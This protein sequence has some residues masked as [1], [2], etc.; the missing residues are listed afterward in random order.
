MDLQ[1][2]SIP[3]IQAERMFD[4][5]P[6]HSGVRED[7]QV[8]LLILGGGSVGQAVLLQAMNQAVLTSTNSVRIDVVDRAPEEAADALA[9]HFSQDYVEREGNSFRI[10]SRNA[11]GELQIRFHGYALRSMALAEFLRT[12]QQGPEPYTYVAVCLPNPDD[13]LYCSYLFEQVFGENIG[14]TALAFRMSQSPIMQAHLQNLP[15]CGRV[16]FLGTGEEYIGLSQVVDIPEEQRIRKYNHMY[17]LITSGMYRSPCADPETLWNQLLYFKRESNRALYH[18]QSAKKYMCGLQSAQDPAGIE[19]QW[20]R[21]IE[22]YVSS[23]EDPQKTYSLWLISRNPDGSLRFPDLVEAAMTEHRRFCYNMA[24]RGW[25]HVPDPEKLTQKVH[26]C[27]VPWQVL[28]QEN[29]DKLIYDLISAPWLL[30]EAAA[31]LACKTK[32]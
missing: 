7:L 2:F 15:W 8:R 12:V 13:N 27:L 4:T 18:H 19:K 11:D 5:L 16:I 25:G 14:C 9:R 22:D 3:Q 28:E 24:S 20:K 32:K 1:I 17:S 23:Q 31:R 26:A 6:L 29:S 10:S 30:Q 21:F